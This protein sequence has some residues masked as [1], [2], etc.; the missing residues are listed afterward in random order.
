[1]LILA[2]ELLFKIKFTSAQD[3]S[4]SLGICSCICQV[5]CF[6]SILSFSRHFSCVP[7]HYQLTLLRVSFRISSRIFCLRRRVL[8]LYPVKLDVRPNVF[9]IG[10]KKSKFQ[11]SIII[12]LFQSHKNTQY[13]TQKQR[14]IKF[15]AGIRIQ[16]CFKTTRHIDSQVCRTVQFIFACPCEKFHFNTQNV[17]LVSTTFFSTTT[18]QFQANCIN[19][20]SFWRGHF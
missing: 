20:S 1:M 16:Y 6:G 18:C 4:V 9:K 14:K 13:H 7:L 19:C 5:I 3:G 2:F 10:Q 8:V 11:L 17:R 12:S 15:K